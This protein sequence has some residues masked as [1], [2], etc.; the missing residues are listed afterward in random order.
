LPSLF[1]ASHHITV[2]KCH[3]ISCNYTRSAV[4]MEL[5][6][7]FSPRSLLSTAS[8][9]AKTIKLCFSNCCFILGWLGTSKFHDGTEPGVR[10]K[11]TVFCTLP[12]TE[13]RCGATRTC[14]LRRKHRGLRLLEGASEFLSQHNRI[15]AFYRC[16]PSLL[17]HHHHQRRVILSLL[18][19]LSAHIFFLQVED[20]ASR[21]F[22]TFILES[23]AIFTRP[24]SF[25]FYIWR[26]PFHFGTENL[27]SDGFFHTE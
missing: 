12:E 14:P 11:A 22:D 9:A 7:R 8:F 21:S 3:L 10:K 1:S 17:H 2:I 24:L 27:T 26:T 4:F 6:F 25:H 18:Q 13:R 23:P 16:F 15:L 5:I 20:S 19:I